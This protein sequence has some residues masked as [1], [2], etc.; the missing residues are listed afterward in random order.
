MGSG[1]MMVEFFSA[2]MVLRVCVKLKQKNHQKRKEKNRKTQKK[3][4]LNRKKGILKD[5]DFWGFVL[6][7]ATKEGNGMRE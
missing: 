4:W 3:I 7:S 2:D 1:N 6:L 5:D